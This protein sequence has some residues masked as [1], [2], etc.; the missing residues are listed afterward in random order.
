MTVDFEDKVITLFSVRAS[1]SFYLNRDIMKVIASGWCRLPGLLAVRLV[2]RLLDCTKLGFWCYWVLQLPLLKPPSSI[3]AIL[4]L[5]ACALRS[6]RERVPHSI[7][8]T[9]PPGRRK[10][11]LSKSYPG[12]DLWRTKTR[13]E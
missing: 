1:T 3:I 4:V 12:P 8:G 10:A 11:S 13:T 7:S 5:H 9:M 2:I 6:A